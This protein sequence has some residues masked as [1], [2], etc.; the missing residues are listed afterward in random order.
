MRRQLPIHHTLYLRLRIENVSSSKVD[1][2]VR[3]FLGRDWN[4]AW[5]NRILLFEDQVPLLV[6]NSAGDWHNR[7]SRRLIL[8]Y[9]DPHEAA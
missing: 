7:A 4:S 6:D 9:F 2:S 8:E 3:A 1:A 5:R